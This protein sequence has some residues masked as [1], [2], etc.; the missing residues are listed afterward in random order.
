MGPKDTLRC[1]QKVAIGC[2]RSTFQTRTTELRDKTAV[3]A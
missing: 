3:G 1:S 2:A